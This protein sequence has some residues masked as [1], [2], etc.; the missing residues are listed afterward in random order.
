[1][2]P[3]EPTQRLTIELEAAE[4]NLAMGALAEMQRSAGVVLGKISAQAQAAQRGA[5]REMTQRGNGADAEP[6]FTPQREA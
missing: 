4:W 6:V 1:M 3:F 5:Q 2:T